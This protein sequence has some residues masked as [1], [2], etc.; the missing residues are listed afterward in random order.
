MH[1]YVINLKQH[2]HTHTYNLI[3]WFHP[4]FISEYADDQAIY[5]WNWAPCAI[6][7][8]HQLLDIMGTTTSG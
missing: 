8:I 2:A 3:V 5:F 4:K 6:Y 1:M 7:F